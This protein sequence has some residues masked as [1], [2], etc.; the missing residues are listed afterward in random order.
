M[1]L[2]TD[3]YTGGLRA[4]QDICARAWRDGISVTC[5]GVGRCDTS[6]LQ[7][8]ARSCSGQFY[9]VT[10]NKGLPETLALEAGLARSI[11]LRDVRV[12]LTLAPGVSLRRAFR[13]RPVREYPSSGS[14]PVVVRLGD[15][16][17]DEKLQLLLELDVKLNVGRERNLGHIEVLS[18]NPDAK[19]REPQILQ[20]VKVANHSAHPNVNAYV[21][22]MVD[23]V[24][25]ALQKR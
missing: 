4:C 5:I 21:M 23:G 1:I 19:E 16:H 11:V 8:I 9:A 14:T 25:V 17:R 10:N 20:D 12:S 6:V 18:R 3:G 15:I 2:V 24:Y 13:P 22:K 7:S